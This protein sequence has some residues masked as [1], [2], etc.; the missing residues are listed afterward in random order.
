MFIRYCPFVDGVP[1]DETCPFI[2]SCPLQMRA[3]LYRVSPIDQKYALMG[4]AASPLGSPIEGEK[5][6]P[7]RKG[8]SRRYKKGIIV[9]SPD[10]TAHAIWGP[11][12]DKWSMM[13]G[14]S[15]FGYPLTDIIP[16][17]VGSTAM[18]QNA[19]I[20]YT[21]TIGA[22]EV[23]G[24]ILERY[25]QLGEEKGI[26]GFPETDETPTLDKEGRYNKFQQ[27]YIYWS[28]RTG[29][30]AWE[31]YGPILKK[32]LDLGAEGSFLGY[33]IFGI[34]KTSDGKGLFSN[35]QG[36]T[37]YFKPPY[38]GPYA[39]HSHIIPEYLKQGGTGG[40]L[41]FPIA[42]EASI[43][44]EAGAGLATFEGGYITYN[45]LTGATTVFNQ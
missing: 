22:R 1:R 35:F 20:Y 19:N 6:T 39:I 13:G 30:G 27:G 45:S 43:L 8:K 32:Y 36:G 12:Y 16:S 9:W 4:G 44:G 5:P 23:H 10:T 29:T 42:D 11:I 3:D 2:Q 24:A 21:A 33:P 31:L 28:P 17:T 14:L 34:S 25:K 40:K 7:D 26:L 41:G 38:L 18:F 15:F 37:I